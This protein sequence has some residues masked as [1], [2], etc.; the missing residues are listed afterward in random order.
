MSKSFIKTTV[1]FFVV[2]TIL[3]SLCA[4]N[5]FAAINDSSMF[6]YNGHKYMLFSDDVKWEEA[7]EACE[8]LGGHLATITSEEEQKFINSILENA[9]KNCYWIGGVKKN[10]AWTWVTGEAFFYTNWAY[11]EPNDMTSQEDFIHVF[12]TIYTGGTG[13]KYVGDWNDAS[14]KGAEYASGFYASQNFG[15]ICEWD[16]IVDKSGD[17]N[18]DETVNIKDATAIQKYLSDIIELDDISFCFADFDSN[19]IVN[20][21]DVTKIQKYIADI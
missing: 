14:E 13:I 7:Q 15:Y 2:L 8:E 18:R 3:S 6:Y 4:T 9:G 1:S 21:Q 20:V 17:V 10:H 12:G 19:G 11:N 16:Q 5:S